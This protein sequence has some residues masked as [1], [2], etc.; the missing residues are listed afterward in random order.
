MKILYASTLYPPAIG[1]SQIHLHEL[2]KLV[3]ASGFEVEILTHTSKYRN[4]WLRLATFRCDAPRRYAYEGVPVRQIGFARRTR[5]AM[6]PWALA[7]YAMI[8]TSARVLGGFVRREL[9]PLET[10]ALVHVT[11]NGR[12][13]LARACLDFARRR[14]VPFVLTPN[15]HP[16]WRGWRYREYDRIY[17]EAD[18]LIALTTAEKRLL[19]EE[20]GASPE[21]VHVGGVGP[22]LAPDFSAKAFRERFG[23]QRRFVLYLGQQL[24]YKGIGELLKAA[25]QVWQTHPDVDFVFIGPQS[26][27]AR[28]LFRGV[29]DTRIH[30]LDAVDLE[31]KTSALAACEVMCLPSAQESFGGAY[32][33]AWTL[34]KPV[35]GGRIPAIAALI[36]EGRDGALTDQDPEEIAAHL[37]SLLSDPARARVMGEAG[38]RKVELHYAWPRLAARLLEVYRTLAPEAFPSPVSTRPSRAAPLVTPAGEKVS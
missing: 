6:L 29:A 37:I 14:R 19:V 32:V 31:T 35:I 12:E 1:G 3:Q 24:K 15:H 4:D 27:F 11:R 8:G 28:R 17:Y 10:P 20:K 22:I 9:D 33:E 36:D 2:A 34:G 38:R 13:F 30:N 7:Y 23:I 5:L 26:D 21:R 25:P 16:R 18:A